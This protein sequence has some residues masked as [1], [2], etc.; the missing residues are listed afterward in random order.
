MSEDLRK[1]SAAGNRVE[2][3][4]KL[5]GAT[6]EERVL[7]NALVQKDRFPPTETVADRP[8]PKTTRV[9]LA[10]VATS[11]AALAVSAVSC[12]QAREALR[13]N[14][15]TS[16]ASVQIADAS[17]VE[18]SAT[19]QLT[20]TN[21][22]QAVARDLRVLYEEAYPS[23]DRAPRDLLGERPLGTFQVHVLRSS[24]APNASTS[25][26]VGTTKVIPEVTE[27]LIDPK[28]VYVW[29]GRAVLWGEL[30]YTDD[31]TGLSKSESWCYLLSF[32]RPSPQEPFAGPPRIGSCALMWGLWWQS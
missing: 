14:L 24:L 10:A 19:V 20:L 22:G 6:G 3:Q 9:A 1:E 27:S 28:E 15:L 5:R 7:D 21:F 13:V 18:S 16:Q 32:H 23:T 12:W 17:I 26:N 11:L 4:A 25:I 8:H 2:E 30:T 31:V 29:S